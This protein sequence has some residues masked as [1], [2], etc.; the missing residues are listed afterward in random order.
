M[1]SPGLKKFEAELKYKESKR[2][3]ST[4]DTGNYTLELLV[5]IIFIYLTNI[6]IALQMPSLYIFYGQIWYIVCLC[7][8]QVIGSTASSV[9]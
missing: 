8:P 1:L 3:E 5:K 7:I 6:Q 9:L 4:I 2:L